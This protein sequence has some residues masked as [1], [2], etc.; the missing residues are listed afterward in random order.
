MNNGLRYLLVYATGLII[1]SVVTYTLVNDSFEDDW[2]EEP[3]CV[4]VEEQPVIDEVVEE[5]KEEKEY[6]SVEQYRDMIRN[7]H[8]NKDES[9]KEVDDLP[10]PYVIDPMEFDTIDDYETV[11]LTYYADGVLTDE[12]DIPVPEDEI[13]ALV[14]IDSLD[15]FG[16]YEEDSVFVRNDEMKTDFEILLDEREY[17]EVVQ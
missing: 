8:Y 4:E 9:K 11:S 2:Y 13:D 17:S 1:G 5:K 15:H 14:G 6:T 12:Q 3:E 16:E 7:L 10:E